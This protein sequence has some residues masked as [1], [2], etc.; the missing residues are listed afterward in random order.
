MNKH[1]Q[2]FLVYSSLYMFHFASVSLVYVQWY[3]ADV[4]KVYLLTANISHFDALIKIKSKKYTT[5][6]QIFLQH[7]NARPKVTHDK[8]K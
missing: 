3:G 4:T 2:Y 6:Q 8:I 7:I 1:L 5:R